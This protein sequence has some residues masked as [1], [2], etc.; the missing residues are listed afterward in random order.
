LQPVQQSA[1][2]PSHGA[3]SSMISAMPILRTQSAKC[4]RA[5]LGRAWGSS[6]RR[7][8][9]S[10]STRPG[11]PLQ[12]H[13][14]MAE[15]TCHAG[16]K[17][18]N[19]HTVG[20]LEDAEPLARQFEHAE[21]GRPIAVGHSE[22]ACLLEG[23]GFRAAGA[24]VHD[25]ALARDQGKGVVRVAHDQHVGLGGVEQSAAQGRADVL[26]SN[27]LHVTA[28]P[29]VPHRHAHTRQL[30]GP[31]RGQGGQVGQGVVRQLGAAG[32]QIGRLDDGRGRLAQVGFSPA[33]AF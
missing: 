8:A 11:Q 14:L 17:P 6:C 27:P 9:G 16:G 15:S 28:R 1:S 29:R 21:R 22:H 12:R 30:G 3:K 5:Q 18:V 23:Q 26:G 24:R 20:H 13:D 4:L 31:R 19:L 7:I 33:T 10:R 2:Q 32:E 25:S